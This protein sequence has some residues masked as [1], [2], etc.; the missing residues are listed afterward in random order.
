[1][2]TRISTDDTLRPY[3]KAWCRRSM[4]RSARRCRRA[5]PWTRPCSAVPTGHVLVCTA[6][7]NLPCGRANTSRTPGPG[8]VAWCRDH[9]NAAFIPAVATGHDTIFA[10][11]CQ[12]GVPQ[13]GRQISDVD[14]RG[15]I[16]N[17]GRCCRETNPC[18]PLRGAAGFDVEQHTCAILPAWPS[19]SICCWS[20]SAPLRG[21]RIAL[22]R[23]KAVPAHCYNSAKFPARHSTRGR[24]ASCHGSRGLNGRPIAVS[25]IW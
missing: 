10:W 11:R 17:I 9:P 14:P 21:R 8:V 16:A 7:A 18:R 4:R 2:C 15:F 19:P 1:M 12:G 22:R 24:T 6:G 23:R 20:P 5:W 3:R 25:G 13:I